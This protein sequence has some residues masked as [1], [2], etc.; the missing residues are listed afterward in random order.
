MLPLKFWVG[1]FLAF[2]SFWWWQ[3]ILGIPPLAAASLQSL[4]LLSHSLLLSLPLSSDGNFLFL[5]G[6]QSSYIGLG[7]TLMVLKLIMSSSLKLIMS[8]K[9]LFLYRVTF[10]DMKD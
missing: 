4:P 10:T 5:S 1:Y 6:H 8:A 9:T 3:L 7:T 2:S